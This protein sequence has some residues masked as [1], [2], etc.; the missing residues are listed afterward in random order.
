[1]FVRVNLD[2]GTHRRSNGNMLDEVALRAGRT[3]LVDS[4]HQSAVV[5]QKFIGIEGSLANRD[6]DIVGLVETE[7]YTTSLCFLDGTFDV[8]SGKLSPEYNQR[9]PAFTGE[10]VFRD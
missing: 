2:A 1:M 3:S 9:A 5:L 7:L 4:V 6:V 10:V 8:L